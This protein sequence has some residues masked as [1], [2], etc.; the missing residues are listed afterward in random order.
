MKIA[1]NEAGKKI[2]AGLDAPSTAICSHCKGSVTLCKRRNNYQSGEVTYSWC[3]V[4]R[5][6]PRCPVRF[7]PVSTIR[8]E[9]D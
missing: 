8:V 3:D 7:N 5:A 6:H 1:V 4:G 9:S 2:I